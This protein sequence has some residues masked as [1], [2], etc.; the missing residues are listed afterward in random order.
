MYLTQPFFNK[1]ESTKTDVFLGFLGKGSMRVFLAWLDKESS[2][3]PTLLKLNIFTNFSW[4]WTNKVEVW[5]EWKLKRRLSTEHCQCLQFRSQ[6]NWVGWFVQLS[7][8]KCLIFSWML[9]LTLTLR[10]FFKFVPWANNSKVYVST[11]R[12][13]KKPQKMEPFGIKPP[14]NL[15]NFE[16]VVEA[17]DGRYIFEL[18]I[19]PWNKFEEKAQCG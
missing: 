7:A 5:V 12:V 18:H 6:L 8:L 14:S 10:F 3:F 1:R 19:C 15:A 17:L 2:E 11:K 13:P 4:N 16:Y 9:R